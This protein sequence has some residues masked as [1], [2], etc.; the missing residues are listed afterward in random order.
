MRILW[1]PHNPWGSNSSI[2]RDQHIIRHIKDEVD[3]VSLSWPTRQD[4]RSLSGL[5]DALTCDSRFEAGV[6]I[7]D[8]RRLPDVTRSVRSDPM[9]ASWINGVLFRKSIRRIVAEHEIDLLVTAYSGYM[10]GLPPFDL[11][12]PVVFDYLDCSNPRPKLGL[13]EEPYLKQ[14]DGVMCVSEMAYHRAQKFSEGSVRMIPNGVDVAHIRSGDGERIR[15]KH[16]LE[17]RNVVSL[18]GPTRCNPPYYLD[19][20]DALPNDTVLLIVGANEGLRKEIAKRDSRQ[21]IYAGSVPY[22]DVPDYY[23]ATDV[24]LYPVDGLVYDDGR[25]PL[26]VFEYVAAGKP[27]VAAPIR[28]VKNLDFANVILAEPTAASFQ[29]G[30]QRALHQG[31]TCSKEIESYKWSRIARDVLSFLKE[32]V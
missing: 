5:A 7:E 28:E 32:L 21:Y 8:V 31:D 6:R 12:I 1:I 25:S 15:R 19:A 4:F 24:G 30:I 16:E 2:R 9:A 20:I 27:V 26:K 3:V 29:K 18:I 23:A 17:N 13:P 11:D 22:D 14:A 10:T